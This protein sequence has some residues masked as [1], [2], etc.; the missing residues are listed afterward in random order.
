MSQISPPNPIPKK[1]FYDATGALLNEMPHKLSPGAAAFVQDVQGRVLL[2]KRADNGYWGLPAG[3]A[4]VGESIS[5]AKKPQN[6]HRGCC[7]Q[8]SRGIHS[9]TSADQ[10]Q[11]TRFLNA[12]RGANPGLFSRG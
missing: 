9:I 10:R 11:Q 2:Q 5:D 3:H 12:F 4:D 7:R 6:T 1:Q 8:S